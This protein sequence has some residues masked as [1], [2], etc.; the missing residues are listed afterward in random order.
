MPPERVI[1]AINGDYRFNGQ[2]CSD[3]RQTKKN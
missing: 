3:E 2:T 1:L